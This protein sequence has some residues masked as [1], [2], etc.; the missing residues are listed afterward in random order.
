MASSA[1]TAGA[2]GVIQGMF[3][4]MT[5]A[6]SINTRITLATT[7]KGDMSITKYVGKMHSLA[8]DMMIVGMPLDHE[9][10]I[11]YIF[12]GL[13]YDYNPIVSALVSRTDAI[14]V[15]EAYAH[16]LSFE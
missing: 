15:A 12:T 14:T 4:S 5:K 13:D 11:S 8:D 6:R 2:W 9:E 7:K 1:T 3:T 10:L 16:F